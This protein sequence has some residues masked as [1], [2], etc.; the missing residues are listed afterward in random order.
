MTR[1][2]SFRHTARAGALIRAAQ[3]LLVGGRLTL[4]DVGRSLP[5]AAHATHQSKRIDRLLGNR[6]LAAEREARYRFLKT[7]AGILPA[8]GRPM[9][10]ATGPGIGGRPRPPKN[11]SETPPGVMRSSGLRRPYSSPSSGSGLVGDF[12]DENVS[13]ATRSPR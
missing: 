8:H 11:G 7:L 13:E 10:I 12:C 4:T 3:A 5:G 9:T 1:T 6:H 2:C